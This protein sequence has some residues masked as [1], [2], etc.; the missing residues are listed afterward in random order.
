MLAILVIFLLSSCLPD[1]PTFNAFRRVE[2]QRLLSNQESKTWELQER[3]AFNEEINLE[4]CDTPR[5]LIFKFT[6]VAKSLDSLFY[7]N[8][9][10]DCGNVADTL[11]GFWFVPPTITAETPIDT[12]V[13][14]W[15][16][17]DTAY[18]KIGELTPDNFSIATYFEKDSLRESFV[19]FPT[20]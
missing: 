7:V 18:F 17:T 9:S 11:K 19:H 3:F 10:V 6:T 12:V 2:V 4:S 13:F 8:P 20:E 1:E 15:E 14:V 16:S 5:Q